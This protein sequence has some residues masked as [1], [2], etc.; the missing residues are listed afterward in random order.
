MVGGKCTAAYFC[1]IKSENTDVIS[2][3][4][5]V[6]SMRECRSRTDIECCGRT[7]GQ[8]FNRTSENKWKE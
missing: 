2:V 5:S 1:G 8:T 3:T 7:L 6:T 4:E